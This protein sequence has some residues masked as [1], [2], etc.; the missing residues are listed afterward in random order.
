MTVGVKVTVTGGNDTNSSNIDIYSL[1]FRMTFS[2]LNCF[3]NTDV[4]I[5][6]YCVP[7][8]EW[9]NNSLLG[10]L[11]VIPFRSDFSLVQK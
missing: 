2:I 9:G 11:K 8:H 7:G 3:L 6:P 10:I 4:Q 5:L 1:D